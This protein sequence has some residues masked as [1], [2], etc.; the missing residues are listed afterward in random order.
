M[1]AQSFLKRKVSTPKSG[2]GKTTPFYNSSHGYNPF[3]FVIYKI[4]GEIL[5]GTTGWQKNN[6]RQNFDTFCRASP[7]L[8][9]AL[10]GKLIV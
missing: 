9:K 2:K 3:Q 10:Q 8:A 7:E 6:E 1:D 5:Q 4:A